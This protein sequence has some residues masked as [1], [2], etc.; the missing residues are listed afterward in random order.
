MF[1][2]F[3]FLILSFLILICIP[4]KKIFYLQTLGIFTSASTLFLSC[5]I[6]SKYDALNSDFQFVTNFIFLQSEYINFNAFFGLDGISIYFFLLTTFLI[7][8]CVLFIWNEKDIKAYLFLLFLLE[9]SLL[10]TF[11]TLNLFLFY[12]LFEFILIPMFLMIGIWGSREK[13]IR[14][15]YLLLAYTIVCSLLLLIGLFY[16]HTVTGTFDYQYLVHYKFNLVEQKF[17]WFVFFISFASKIPMFPLHIWLPEAHVEA[18]TVG[19][20]L[21]AGILLKLGVY[22]FLRYNIILF[23][24]ASV[25]FSPLVYSLSILGIIYASLIAIKQTDFKRIIAYSSIAHMNLVTIGVF[26]G[27][28]IGIEGS[29]VQSISHGFV[30]SALFFLIGIL[31]NRHHSKL[32][33][34]YSGLVVIMPLYSIFFIFFTMSN[35]ALP[36]T[37]SFVGEFLLLNGI[38]Q[39]NIFIAIISTTSVIFSGVYSLWLSNRLLFGSLK[40]HFDSVHFFDLKLNEIYILFILFFFSLF[41]GLFPSVCLKHISLSI[42]KYFIL[43]SI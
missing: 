36:G 39:E 14:A 42:T 2:I 8:L 33:H 17:L 41:L 28:I 11:S 43:T 22:G 40:I 25:Y 32:I 35:I 3:F 10:L 5:I 6:L 26:S 24:E 7:F 21:L 30:S 20:V 16:I 31:Y 38:F 15:A 27:N 4:K 37:S 18:P 12:I 13:K 1:F 23:P 19:S 9:I 34:Y 29:V